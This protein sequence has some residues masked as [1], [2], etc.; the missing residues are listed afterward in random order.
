MDF[1]ESYL[2]MA[3]TDPN[4]AAKASYGLFKA[5]GELEEKLKV[6]KENLRVKEKELDEVKKKLAKSQKD[7]KKKEDKQKKEIEK[8]TKKMEKV[9]IGGSKDMVKSSVLEAE[10]EESK[11]LKKEKNE[12]KQKISE[13][14]CNLKK[15]RRVEAKYPKL[16]ADLKRINDRRKE[17][18]E[19]KKEEKRIKQGYYEKLKLLKQR[20]IR[21]KLSQ[22]IVE[23]PERDACKERQIDFLNFKNTY[24]N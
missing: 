19:E 21:E 20:E 1:M 18:I 13:L 15:A 8:L 5:F 2:H 12:F 23:N 3:K 4:E 7:S 16:L 6:T 17:L 14:E 24:Y 10:K 9:S 11:K 22:Y